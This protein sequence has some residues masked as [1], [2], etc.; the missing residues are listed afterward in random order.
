MSNYTSLRRFLCCATMFVL[1][2]GCAT[3]GT[4]KVSGFLGYYDDFTADP[5]DESLLWWERDGFDWS[6]Y[7]AVMLDP[8]TIYF[9][10]EAQDREIQ[11]DELKK[12]TDG[13]RDAVIEELG[14]AYP[15]VGMHAPD[16]LRI[17]CAITDIVPSNAALNV[18]T[19]L[20]AFVPVDMGSAAI[21]V[22]F[23]DSVTG[24]RLAASVDQELGT[25]FDGVSGFTRLGHARSAFR[26]W[27]K[28]LRTA[29]DTNP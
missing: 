11:P 2:T 19:S 21:E 26:E 29:L 25:P 1:I 20:A 27:A 18:A 10:A 13:F 3:T 15:V 9:D 8:V 24:E 23:L 16:V 28:E 17:R 14:D 7:R 22:E 6:D 4:Q 5:A 12:L